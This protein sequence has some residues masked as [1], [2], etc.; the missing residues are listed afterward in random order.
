MK[1]PGFGTG[2]T[3]RA[4][5]SVSAAVEPYFGAGGNVLISDANN[6]YTVQQKIGAG[7]F[8]DVYLVTGTRGQQFALKLLR[9]WNIFPE[10]RSEVLL[11][12]ER[13][14]TC[15][16]INSGYLVKS[17]DKGNHLGNPFFLMEYCAGGSLE[18]RLGKSFDEQTYRSL[19]IRMLKGLRDLHREG[20]IHRDLKPVNILFNAR[21][22][23]FLTDFGISGY[24]QSRVT[25]CNWLGHVKKIFGTLV[26]MPPE[27]LDSREAFKAL[28]PVT[29]IWAFGVTMHQLLCKGA[30]P[31]GDYLEAEEETYLARM[32]Q[33]KWIGFD[34]AQQYLAPH[35]I[36]LIEGCLQPEAKHRFQSAEQVMELLDIT[37]QTGQPRLA[38]S[39]MCGNALLRVMQGEQHGLAFNLTKLAQ[40]KKSDVLTI[41]WFDKDDPACNDLAIVE[42]ASKYI[43][44]YHA[45]LEL[46]ESQ[47][48]WHIRDG[49][50][51]KHGS[52]YA[53]LPSTN[54][55]YVN[56]Q[57]ADEEGL[58]LL[59]GDIITLGDT[60]LRL[61]IF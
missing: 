11:R 36:A 29:D 13:E 45:T 54:G 1:I 37:E 23:A 4:K 34:Q 58:P 5:S 49:Q 9:M 27:Q 19:A 18:D 61:E 2:S 21:N 30:L 32:K 50:W 15:S 57:K 42:P 40:Q 59:P 39:A 60:T 6:L 46:E 38:S 28:G 52:T 51:R 7:G 55:V 24:L 31:F 10:D 12:F 17:Y 22:E 56:S 20:I 8:A 16:R 53:W 48:Q 14:Y 35:W 25:L 44:R 43:S 26:Y 47:A 41:G 3:Q 33:A